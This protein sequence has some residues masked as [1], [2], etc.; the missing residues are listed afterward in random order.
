MINGHKPHGQLIDPS[1]M[2]LKPLAQPS[3]FVTPIVQYKTA[4]KLW[5]MYIII[6][7]FFLGTTCPYLCMYLSNSVMYWNN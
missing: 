2:I 3:F 7:N 5:N 1:S 4:N 6:P